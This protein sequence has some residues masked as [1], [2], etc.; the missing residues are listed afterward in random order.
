MLGHIVSK[1]ATELSYIKRSSYMKGVTTEINWNFELGVGDGIYILI[2]VIVGVMQRDQLNQQHQNKDTF[3]RPSV[4]NAQCVS[5]NEKIPDAGINCNYAVDKYSQ[6]YGENVSCFRHLVKNNILQPY[7]TQNDFITSNYYPNDN[8]GYNLYVLVICHH[9]D[10]SSAQ[11]INVRFDF[12][13][14][15]PTATNLVGY[16]LLLM[17]KLV[18]VGS[19]GQ[20][21]F[22]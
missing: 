1:A 14:P 21:L 11:P 9:K 3:Y 22:G 18:S 20:R 19:D 12:R 10:Y 16:V 17:K 13:P 2:Y 5:G 15:V 6:A 7:I 4:V 8:L